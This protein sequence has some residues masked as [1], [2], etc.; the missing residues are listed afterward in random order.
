[1]PRLLPY[2]D[3]TPVPWRNGG[4]VTRE[5]A[6]CFDPALHPDFL[7]RVSIAAVQKDGPFSRFEGVDRSIAVLHGGNMQLAADEFRTV[8]TPDGPAF[9]FA[10]EPDVHASVAG[11][12]TTDL[13]VMTRRDRFVHRMQKLRVDQPREIV[14]DGDETLVVFID[15]ATVDCDGHMFTAQPLDTLLDLQVGSRVTVLPNAEF[16]VAFLIIQI[17]AKRS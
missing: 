11:C 2:A 1:M 5:V 14:A 6:V 7:W 16:E 13:N 12:E 3:L 10:G 15:P 17:W 4:G 8:L 9:S